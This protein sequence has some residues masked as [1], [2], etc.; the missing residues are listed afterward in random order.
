MKN[1][2]CVICNNPI[3]KGDLYFHVHQRND[4]DIDLVLVVHASH[5]RNWK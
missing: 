3:A 1:K 5:F 4:M 2:L